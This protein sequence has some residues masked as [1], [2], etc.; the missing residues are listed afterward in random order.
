MNPFH[1]P[2]EERIESYNSKLL[3]IPKLAG[4]L[5]ITKQKTKIR[6]TKPVL[7]EKNEHDHMS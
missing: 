2:M 1:R 7:Q 4:L 3:L 6:K 5:T